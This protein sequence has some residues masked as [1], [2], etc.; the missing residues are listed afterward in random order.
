MA[1]IKRRQELENVKTSLK[2]LRDEIKV[3]AHLAT[4][5]LKDEWTKLEPKL[6]EAEKYADAVSDAAVESAKA[7]QRS[8]GKLRDRLRSLRGQHELRPH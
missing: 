3:Y 8:A 4:M 7:L 6:L 2:E 5:D 1:D